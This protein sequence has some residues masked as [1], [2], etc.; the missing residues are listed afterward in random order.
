MR[1]GWRVAIV[2]PAHAMTVNAQNALLKTLE[3]PAAR[4]LL[5]LVSSRPSGLLPTVRSRCQR[6]ELPHPPAEEAWRWLQTRLESPSA[7]LLELAGGAPLL[8]LELAPHFA[9]LETQMSTL[10]ADFLS[11]RRDV[12]TTAGDMLGEGLPVRLTWLEV[13]LRAVARARLVPGATPVTLPGDARL[14]RVAAEVNI[15]AVF[16]VVDRL[17][18]TRRLLDGSAQ[19]QLLVEVWLLALAAAFGRKGVN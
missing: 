7:R 18:E 16:E 14:Q 6:V 15:T 11:G 17:R 13:W 5:M 3:E 10:V 9:E 4:T 19:P 8:A 1:R 12:T 2:S